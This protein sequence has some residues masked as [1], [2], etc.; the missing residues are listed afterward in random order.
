[1]K[2]RLLSWFLAMVMVLGLLPATAWA[3][4]IPFAAAA[5][6][7]TLEIEKSSEE[8]A[9]TVVT[10]YDEYWNPVK[11]EERTVPLYEVKVPADAEEATL[12]FAEERL[13]YNS[14]FINVWFEQKIR[15]NEFN[16]I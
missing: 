9:Y 3:E 4:T 7:E 2:K 11:T 6:E 12:S 1:M 14:K 5:G 15:D 10:E 8:Y 13:A 16:K